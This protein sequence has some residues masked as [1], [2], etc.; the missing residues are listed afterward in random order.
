MRWKVVS[1]Y[2]QIA[3]GLNPDEDPVINMA[4]RTPH[5]TITAADARRA[6]LH[7]LVWLCRIGG[8]GIIGLVMWAGFAM[9]DSRFAI[10]WQEIFFGL[11]AAALGAACVA[12]G[13]L[14][15]FHTRRT[16]H[17]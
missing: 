1:A 8:G 7:I 3:C 13:E 11:G 16:Q 2:V 15:G 17:D 9:L 5:R 6:Y 14:L 12:V 10:T 4:L